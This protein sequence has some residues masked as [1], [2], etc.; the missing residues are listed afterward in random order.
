MGR[1]GHANPVDGHSARTLDAHRDRLATP[2]PETEAQIKPQGRCAGRRLAGQ[3]LD[4][5]LVRSPLDLGDQ[6][7][8]D[9]APSVAREDVD[10]PEDR[11]DAQ[12]VAAVD[13]LDGLGME[14]GEG[15]PA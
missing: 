12:L 3:P 2:D 4:A 11:L 15:G 8:G 14:D 10:P 7:L 9:M 1:P 5:L 13:T 6:T